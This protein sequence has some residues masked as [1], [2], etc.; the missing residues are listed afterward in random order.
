MNDWIFDNLGWFL[1]AA[2]CG[3]LFG[4]IKLSEVSC[5]AQWEQSGLQADWG[6]V[7]GCVVKTPSGRW[8]PADSLRDMDLNP[9]KETNK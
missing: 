4:A 1:F 3:L 8:L 2:I 5:H 6:I 7:K 9:T